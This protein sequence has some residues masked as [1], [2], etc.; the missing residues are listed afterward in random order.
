M[1]YLK[2]FLPYL[3]GNKVGKSLEISL[4]EPIQWDSL[5]FEET[6]M[7]KA[8]TAEQDSYFSTIELNTLNL[9]DTFQLL[10]Y[11]PFFNAANKA[12]IQHRFSKEFEIHH[13]AC[14][15]KPLTI[16]ELQSLLSFKN[17]HL[18]LFAILKSD[19]AQKGKLL[20]KKADGSFC[21]DSQGNI[22]SIS[23]LGHTE[24]GLSF[25]FSSGC[26]PCGLYSIDGVMAQANNPYLFG[27]YRRLILNFMPEIMANLPKDHH[28]LSWWRQ[29][30]VASKLGR[31][32]L[33]I[34]GTGRVNRN[35]LT[36]YF[37]FV[38]TSGC[39]ATNE[40]QLAGMKSHDQRLLLDA[41][42]SAI[43]EE[44]IF[45]NESKIHGLLYVVEFDDN[46]ARLEF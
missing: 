20:L 2:T 7:F 28:E 34:H 1:D 29:A 8:L 32:L 17:N 19:R 45:E 36:P 40:V 22:W 11:L 13:S 37:P 3:F 43:G 39:L 46:L 44:A 35:P 38:P 15:S 10:N 25:N 6:L 26:T 9:K 18:T 12:L 24:R 42:M 27:Q 21:L 31:S 41:M 5:S 16:P 14:I 30:E 33:R 23:I 4:P